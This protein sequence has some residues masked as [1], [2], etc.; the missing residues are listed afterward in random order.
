MVYS[1]QVDIPKN[2]PAPLDYNSLLEMLISEV[3][4]SFGIEKE[5]LYDKSRQEPVRYARWIVW[6]IMVYNQRISLKKAGDIFGG[7]DHTSVI[8]ALRNLPNVLNE[9]KWV[10]V[11]YDNVLFRCGIDPKKL[12]TADKLVSQKQIDKKVEAYRKSLLKGV[13]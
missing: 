2:I 6:Q 11:I 10:K 12:R 7:Y 3:V 13:V 4:I 8:H 9:R 5:L 1:Y